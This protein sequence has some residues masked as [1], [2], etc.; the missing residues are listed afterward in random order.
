[1]NM[2][3]IIQMLTEQEEPRNVILSFGLIV[4]KLQRKT[5]LFGEGKTLA[6]LCYSYKL[7]LSCSYRQ[8]G[9]FN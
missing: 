4:V 5:Y 1:M 7:E 6:S 9:F 8:Y 2:I 3:M